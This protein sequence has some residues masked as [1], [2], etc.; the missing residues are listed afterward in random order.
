MAIKLNRA[1][2]AHPWFTGISRHHLAA[3]VEELAHPWEVAAE[4]H[5]NQ[6]RGG[7][8][9]RTA[10][11][12][13]RHRLVFV[14]RLV[15]TLIHLRHDLPHAVLGLLFGVDR[16]TLPPRRRPDPH[17]AGRAWTRGPEPPGGASAHLG[18]RLRPRPRRGCGT[19][20]GRHRDPSPAA[21]RGTGR[22]AGVRLRQ[23]EAQAR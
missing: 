4:N 18:R 16:S 12:G 15:A 22:P 7:S 14:D 11:A 21:T 23:E 2:L 8:R 5:K 17:P 10:G 13:A 19:A 3:L 20:A 9:K 6:V 1:V